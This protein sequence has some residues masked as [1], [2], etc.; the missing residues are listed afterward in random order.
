LLERSGYRPVRHSHTMVRP[1]LDDIPD[2]PLPDGIELRPAKPEHFRQIWEAARD[3]FTD[4]WG[5]GVQ[6]EDDYREWLA[7]PI[8]MDAGLWQVAWDTATNQV[9]GQVR[10]FIDAN[11]N[12]R[13]HRLRGYTEFI[14]VGRPWRK[15]GLARALIALSLRAQQARGM[16]ES[17]LGVDS[18]NTSGANRVYEDCG[19]EVVSTKT[20]YQKLL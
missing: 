12:A 2:Y 15:R 16:T 5:A 20:T 13:Y 18:Q 14:S 4:H 8:L 1:S 10:T 11:D 3:A 9:A 19:F 17:T 6:T 7:D